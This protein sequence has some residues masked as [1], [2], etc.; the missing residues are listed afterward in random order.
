MA[1]PLIL[2]TNDDGI[3]AT[4]VHSLIRAVESFGDVVGV[5]PAEG[6]SG[7]SHAI[8]VKHPLRIHSV[9]HPK[10][11]IHKCYGTPV[12]SVKMAFNCVLD[13]YPDLIVSGINHG[14]NASVSV[15]YSGTMA[16]AMEGALHGVPSIGFSLMNH[17]PQADFSC[18]IKIASQVTAMVLQ[19]G[20]PKNTCLNVNIPNVGIEQIKGIKICRQTRGH[21]IEEFDKRKDPFGG[22]YYWLSG[23]FNNMEPENQETD[24]WAL[25]NNYVSIVPVLV[26]LTCRQTLAKLLPWE[27][28]LNNELPFGP[29]GQ[30]HAKTKTAR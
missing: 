6:Q 18:A 28:A 29:N 27:A 1:K 19:Q 24:E 5:I 23:N 15:L 8:T 14:G 3:H 4:G 9:Q 22:E 25:K 13:R 16:A 17:S 7:M 30:K 11:E 10:H 26:D 12:D 21:W 20:L 2:V